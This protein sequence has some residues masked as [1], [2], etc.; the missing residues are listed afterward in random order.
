MLVSAP[1][2][3]TQFFEKEK[4]SCYQCSRPEEAQSGNAYQP[5]LRI[6]RYGTHL[7]EATAY[8]GAK[9]VFTRGPTNGGC[10]GSSGPAQAAPSSF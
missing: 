9:A 3:G 6:S 8:T 4:T 7:S 5:Q 10:Q 2:A 1:G